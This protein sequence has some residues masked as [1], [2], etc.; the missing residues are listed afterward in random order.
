MTLGFGLWFATLSIL[1]AVQGTGCANGWDRI[2]VGP[3]SL[4]RLALLVLWSVSLAALA[5][6]YARCRRARAQA[7]PGAGRFLW[8]ASAALTVAAVAA[9]CWVGLAIFVPSICR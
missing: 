1:Y 2:E 6:F 5:A 7:A 3:A 8:R 9:T 4:L